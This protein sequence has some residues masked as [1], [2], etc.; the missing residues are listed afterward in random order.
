M[1][2]HQCV[3]W[4]FFHRD[5]DKIDDCLSAGYIQILLFPKICI[6][7]LRKGG[8]VSYFNFLHPDKL[9]LL[10]NHFCSAA[11]EIN[12][13]CN[14][15]HQKCHKPIFSEFHYR[16]L[17]KVLFCIH[18]VKLLFKIYCSI[19]DVSGAIIWQYS[20]SMLRFKNKQLL[21]Y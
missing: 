17:F 21:R 11:R 4:W 10:L 5:G 19:Y 9:N 18:K 6:F 20:I 1:V 2:F 14:E 16:L 7:L 13:K 15:Q 3:H 8:E 12:T